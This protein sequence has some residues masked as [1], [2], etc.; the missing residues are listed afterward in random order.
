MLVASRES[1]E[2]LS[3]GD[4]WE[5]SELTITRRKEK[6]YCPECREEVIM[7]LGS[8]R[9]WHF[10]HKSGL[11]CQNEFERESDYHL[12]GKMQLYQWLK[13]QG[14][15]AELERYDP[16]IK[17]KPDIMFMLNGKKYALEYQ[18]S[19][20]SEELFIKR[21][22][23]YLQN[24]YIPLWIAAA[25]LINRSGAS[26]ISLSNFLYLFMRRSRKVWNLSAFCPISSQF[27]T[28]QHAIPIS[29]RKTITSLEVHALDSLTIE[30]LVHPDSRSFPTMALW[31]L[32]LQKYKNQFL[33]YQGPRPDPLL[34]TLY[35]NR[36]NFLCL[37]PQ[38]G[39]PVHSAPFIETPPLIWQAYLYLDVFRDYKPGEFIKFATIDD[40]FNNR[41]TSGH[42]HLRKLPLAGKG[43]SLDAVEE[44]IILLTKLKIFERISPA[45]FELI[46]EMLIPKSVDEQVK[47]EAQFYKKYNEVILHL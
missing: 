2:R 5:K 27:V 29:S 35:R 16:V 12:S 13:K 7:K 37:P 41:V 43:S 4:K 32:H 9:I 21:T 39:L 14:I 23:N 6:F 44:Y 3:L 36:L 46:G 25:N 8:K 17:Q 31:Q 33:A 22:N 45:T 34:Q 24:G 11:R 10:S 47:M 30:K 40:A 15:E 26:T 18:C 38:L 19:T 28:L 20:I 42:I 1:G